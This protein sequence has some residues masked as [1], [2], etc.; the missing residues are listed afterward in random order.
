MITPGWP[1]RAAG[2][3]PQCDDQPSGQHAADPTDAEHIRGDAPPTTSMTAQSEHRP[4]F[5]SLRWLDPVPWLSP[6]RPE[7]LSKADKTHSCSA[8]IHA[9]TL[10][11]QH[12]GH[13]RSPSPESIALLRRSRP[14]SY[15]LALASPRTNRRRACPRFWFHAHR[16]LSAA[17]KRPGMVLPL[18]ESSG[19]AR[20]CFRSSTS[21]CTSIPTGFLCAGSA[22][23]GVAPDVRVRV[24]A[25]RAGRSAAA[26]CPA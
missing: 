8:P 20:T 6:P 5:I 2:R 12:E 13:G 15:R 18:P 25:E 23:Q 4:P 26:S 16:A 14:N 22:T 9:T 19:R 21:I 3:T 10:I 24:M 17:R 1:A 11:D 7:S